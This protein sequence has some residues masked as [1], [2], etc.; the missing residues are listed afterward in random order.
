MASSAHPFVLDIRPFRLTPG[1]F[2]YSIGRIGSMKRCSADTY[3]TFEEARQAAQADL[4][5]RIAA[6]MRAAEPRQDDE[7]G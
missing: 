1:R 3:A 6:W 7:S 2:I 4:N 5:E